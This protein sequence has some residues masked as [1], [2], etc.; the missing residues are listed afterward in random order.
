MAAL[1]VSSILN[2]LYLTPIAIRGFMK[3]PQNP[4][5]DANIRNI[6]KQHRWVIIPPVLTAFGAFILFFFAGEITNFLTPMLPVGAF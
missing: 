5:D 4:E 1:I 6:R 2:V 3:P